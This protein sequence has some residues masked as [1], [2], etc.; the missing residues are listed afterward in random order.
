MFNW[1]FPLM[2]RVAIVAWWFCPFDLEGGIV[3]P[4]LL[5][6]V[7][8]SMLALKYATFSVS[9][10]DRYQTCPE[11]EV[12]QEYINQAHLF[13]GWAMKNAAIIEYEISSAAARAGAPLGKLKIYLS[14]ANVT[15]ESAKWDKFLAGSFG[16]VKHESKMGTTRSYVTLRDVC[17]ALPTQSYNAPV[18]I[19]ADALFNKLGLFYMFVNAVIPLTRPEIYEQGANMWM[20]VYYICTSLVVMAFSFVLVGFLGSVVVQTLRMYVMAE[21]LKEMLQFTEPLL[22]N[23]MKCSMKQMHT[24]G[25][26]TGAGA[27]TGSAPLIAPPPSP[28]RPVS[29][30]GGA[31]AQCMVPENGRPRSRSNSLDSAGSGGKPNSKSKSHS[32]SV[33][34]IQGPHFQDSVKL[35]ANALNAMGGKSTA[36]V[37]VSRSNTAPTRANY[38]RESSTTKFD[39]LRDVYDVDVNSGGLDQLNVSQDDSRYPD[40][41]NSEGEDEADE[42]TITDSQNGKSTYTSYSGFS[43]TTCPKILELDEDKAIVG[44][45]AIQRRYRGFQVRREALNKTAYK[46]AA[47]TVDDTALHMLKRD[48]SKWGAMMLPIPKISVH[49]ADNV[50]GWMYARSV[51]QNY[52]TRVRFRM[53]VY[54]GCTSLLLFVL[55]IFIVI[56]LSVAEDPLAMINNTLVKQALLAVFVSTIYVTGV[57]FTGAMANWT[58]DLHR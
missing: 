17:I 15:E 52:G 47:A 14:E 4:V 26:A 41:E 45:V 21:C 55:M 11:G 56:Y 20:I 2:L 3:I 19:A 49:T 23:N 28:P 8:R 18:V 12:L 25:S 10:Y 39:W 54:V 58:F 42:T 32:N 34:S 43:A 24:P 27:G 7:H 51:M 30:K 36:H 16:S 44:A 6:V 1:V 48:D 29:K 46:K 31:N 37:S 33:Q 53:D 22:L 57:V 38:S 50:Y 40:S 9:E 13:S 5:Y 35:E